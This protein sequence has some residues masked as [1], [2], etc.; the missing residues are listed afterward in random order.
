[1]CLS[2]NTGERIE[3]ERTQ[4][5]NVEEQIEAVKHELQKPFEFETEYKEKPGGWLWLR[6]N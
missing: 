1:M 2:G 5:A 6:R 4:L 3:N